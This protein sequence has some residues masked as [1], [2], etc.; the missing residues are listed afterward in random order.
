MEPFPVNVF[1]A[2]SAFFNI[3]F[4]YSYQ[5]NFFPIFKGLHK[6]TDRRMRY[7]SFI[8]LLHCGIPYITVGF[9]GYAMKGDSEANFFKSLRE[10]QVNKILFFVIVGSFILSLLFSIILYFFSGRNNFIS[11]VSIIRKKVQ[12]MKPTENEE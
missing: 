3:T 9:L 10:A 2:V 12:S 8:G 1:G 5:V 4:A 6:P 7:A 11:L